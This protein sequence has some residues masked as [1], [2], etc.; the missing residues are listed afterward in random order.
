LNRDKTCLYELG[1]RMS[2]DE[3]CSPRLPVTESPFAIATQLQ[4]HSN[5][6]KFPLQTQD[7]CAI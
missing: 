7:L 4:P 6:T 2:K 5:T 3:V 1:E